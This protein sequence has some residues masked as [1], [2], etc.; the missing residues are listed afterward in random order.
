MWGGSVER[1][2]EPM[3]KNRI[4]GGADQGER[5]MNREALVIKGQAA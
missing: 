1:S 5:A 3:N 2:C 4:E